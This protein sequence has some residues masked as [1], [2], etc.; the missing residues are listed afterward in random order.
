M[1]GRGDKD[2][3]FRL[4]LLGF[5]R[6]HVTISHRHH[7]DTYWRILLAYHSRVISVRNAWRGSMPRRNLVLATARRVGASRGAGASSVHGQARSGGKLSSP[8]AG[9][10]IGHDIPLSLILTCTV[11]TYSCSS[12]TPFT[13]GGG[14]SQPTRKPFLC[15]SS[16]NNPRKHH[17]NAPI[18][19]IPCLHCGAK[20]SRAAE[21]LEP[22]A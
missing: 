17:A 11:A 15:G 16:E 5:N 20:R 21:S 19:I 4:E 7:V 22:V 2:P 9:A 8:G 12:P 6:V 18:T 1:R 14:L 10:T 3:A 13:G